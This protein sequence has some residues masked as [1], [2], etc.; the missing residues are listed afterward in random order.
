MSLRDKTAIVGIGATP[1][2]KR[3]ES[4]PQTELELPGQAILGALDDAGLTISDL[5]GFTIYSSSCDPAQVG[6]V[7]GVPEIRFAAS[8]TSG[9]GGAAGVTN[10]AAFVSGAGLMAPGHSFAM[11]TPGPDV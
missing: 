7:L 1:Y 9:G 10:F 3:G 4:L 8:L 5:D 6:S 2:Y 11:L